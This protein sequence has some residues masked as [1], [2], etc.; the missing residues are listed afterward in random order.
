MQDNCEIAYSRQVGNENQF[1]L[2]LSISL[3][4]IC[5]YRAV[6]FCFSRGSVASYVTVFKAKRCAKERVQIYKP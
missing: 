1:R 2:V 5:D 4:C 3:R 6:G